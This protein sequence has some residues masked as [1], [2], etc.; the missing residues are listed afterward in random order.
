MISRRIYIVD[1]IILNGTMQFKHLVLSFSDKELLNHCFPILFYIGGRNLTYNLNP[2]H[3]PN[4][5]GN[6]FRVND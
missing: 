3:P 6:T 5:M 4:I 2:L 1:P